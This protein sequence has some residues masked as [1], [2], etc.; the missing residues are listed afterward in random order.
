MVADCR[1]LVAERIRQRGPITV[2][3]F[4]DLALYAP[5][6]GYYARAAQRSGRTG[7]FFTSVDIGPLYGTLLA[8]ELAGLHERM[9]A[10]AAAAREGVRP[11]DVIL[12]VNGQAVETVRDASQALQAIRQGS[13]ARM[14]LWK[15]GQETFVVVTK[16]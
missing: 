13:A 10:G 14:L 15:Q 5:G 16:E 8:D 3:E 1:A 12:K 9:R 4:I 6:V 2:A 11:G 7:D